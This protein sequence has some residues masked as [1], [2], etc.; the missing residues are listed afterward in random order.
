MKKKVAIIPLRNGSKGLPGKN[1]QKFCELPLYYWTVLQ[2]LKF[3]DECIVT[4]DIEDILYGKLPIPEEVQLRNRP[5]KLA[6]DTAKMESVIQDVLTYTGY[7]D[8][9]ILLLQATSPLRA[10]EDI[11]KS[12]DLFLRDDFEIVFTV[13]ESD[14]SLLKNGFMDGNEFKSVSDYGYLFQNRQ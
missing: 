7:K 4:T 9:I 5:T 10:N 11:Q 12:L 14:P 1:T 6:S 2:A 13:S 8:S 3:A